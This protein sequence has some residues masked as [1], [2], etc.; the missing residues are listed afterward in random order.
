MAGSNIFIEVDEG[1][2]RLLVYLYKLLNS[3]IFITIF[4][5]P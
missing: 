2:D 5:S 1:L 4:I 3:N